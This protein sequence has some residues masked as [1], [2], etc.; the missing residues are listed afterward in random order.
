MSYRC[1]LLGCRTNTAWE[2]ANAKP[3]TMKTAAALGA[4]KRAQ[5]NIA[6]AIAARNVVVLVKRLSSPRAA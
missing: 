3:P 2:K 4:L 1:A 6:R 5:Q